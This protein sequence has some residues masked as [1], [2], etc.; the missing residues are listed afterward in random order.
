MRYIFQLSY[1]SKSKTPLSNKELEE[2]L[3]TARQHNV[4]EKITGIL[5]YNKGVFLQLL[6]GEENQ[7]RRLFAKIE[8][9]E[10]HHGIHNFFEN[11]TPKRVFENWSMAYQNT[12]CYEPDIVQ[13]LQDLVFQFHQTDIV[14]TRQEWMSILQAMRHEL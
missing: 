13:R 3:A 10:R 7:V 9:D 8:S 12:E 11:F 4:Q 5:V 1:M 14:A 2:L 6:E